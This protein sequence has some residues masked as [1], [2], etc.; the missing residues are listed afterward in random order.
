MKSG[1]AVPI[2]GGFELRH[3]IAVPIGLSDGAFILGDRV[4]VRTFR[5]AGG[6]GVGAQGVVV[7]INLPL[8]SKY[9]VSRPYQ[10][11][12]EGCPMKLYRFGASNLELV[13]DKEQEEQDA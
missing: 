10:V 4:R 7:A 13:V 6:R 1:L 8:H 5:V 9:G 3:R 2:P 11:L 12:L